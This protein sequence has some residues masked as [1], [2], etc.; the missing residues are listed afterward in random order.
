M[1]WQVAVIWGENEK[2]VVEQKI[3]IGQKMRRKRVEKVRKSSIKNA[4]IKGT[5]KIAEKK[6]CKKRGKWDRIWS[7]LGPVERP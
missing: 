6:Y 3:C 7:D 1:G 5:N 4:P 2:K